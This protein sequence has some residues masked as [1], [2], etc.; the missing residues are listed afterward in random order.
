MDE[1]RRKREDKKIQR[2]RELEAK[3]AHRTSSCGGAMKLG[4]KK[5]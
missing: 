5:I 4:A 2:Q 3:R 1:A